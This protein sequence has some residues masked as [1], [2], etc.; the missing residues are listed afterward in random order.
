MF[1][2][3][4]IVAITVL[5]CGS[6]AAADAILGTPTA[7]PNLQDCVVF[8]CA[9]Q[10][11]FIYDS[12]LFSGPISITGL[13]FFNSFADAPGETFD[14]A[15]YTF[16]LA[17]SATD[18]AS[19]STV[20]AD[21]VGADVQLFATVA[22]G[23][24]VIPPAFSFTGVPFLYDP[25]NGDLLIEILKSGTSGFSGFTDYNTDFA[26]SRLF[27]LGDGSGVSGDV[28]FAPVVDVIGRD[29]TPAPVPEPA[30]LTL[31]G[32]GLAWVARRLKKKTR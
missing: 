20:F 15:T 19:P 16:R 24:D 25:A 29:V 21:N 22:L 11:Q 2:R 32:L 7:D 4:L 27:D 14:P 3:T 23:G 26:A 31:T 6:Y 30:S 17:T 13:E 9:T 12:S 1:K 8:G 5:S 18:F 28:G 10:A